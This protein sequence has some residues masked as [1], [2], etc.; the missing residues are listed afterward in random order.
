MPT[1]HVTIFRRIAPVANGECE[2]NTTMGAYKL[3]MHPLEGISLLGDTLEAMA[4]EC[5]SFSKD[6]NDSEHRSDRNLYFLI[7]DEDGLPVAFG[8]PTKHDIHWNEFTFIGAAS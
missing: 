6:S 1:E 5:L 2:P 3:P 8:S 4:N 7:E